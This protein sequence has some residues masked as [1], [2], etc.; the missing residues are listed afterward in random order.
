VTLG[1]QVRA[2]EMSVPPAASEL[3]WELARVGDGLMDVLRDVREISRGIH[4]ATLSER[5]WSPP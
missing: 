5:A 4:P 3:K 1:L 2:A